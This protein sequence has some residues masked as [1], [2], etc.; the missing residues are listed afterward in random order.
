MN[1]SETKRLVRR[2]YDEVLN[3][4]NESLLSELLAPDFCSRFGTVEV[5]AAGYARAVH[6]SLETLPDLWVEVIAQV[7][8]GD[9]VATRWRA[10]GTRD[11]QPLRLSAMHFHRVADGKLAEHWEE[12]DPRPLL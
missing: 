1:P 9:L 5:D 6:R 10:S 8:E 2:Y 7:A 3:G 11:G 4:R 12:L